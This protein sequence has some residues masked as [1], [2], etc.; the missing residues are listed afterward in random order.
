MA[1]KTY[2]I[3]VKGS[4]TTAKLIFTVKL[5]RELDAWGINKTRYQVEGN[6]I[7]TTDTNVVDVATETFIRHPD[8]LEITT[9]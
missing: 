2:T 1:K 5:L 9:V 3:K 6:V 7:T 4:S 8:L